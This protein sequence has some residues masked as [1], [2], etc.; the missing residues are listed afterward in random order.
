MERTLR[1][2]CKDGSSAA[3]L[4]MEA[5]TNRCEKA[6]IGKRHMERAIRRVCSY[7]CVRDEMQRQGPH[8]RAQDTHTPIIGVL[9]F[10]HPGVQVCLQQISMLLCSCA[11]GMAGPLHAYFS[12]MQAC[13]VIYQGLG[14]CM[15]A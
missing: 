13:N 10:V 4:G 9:L 11:Q 2:V 7:V 15:D 12:N 1:R 6:T 3:S 5:G 14:T 8:A